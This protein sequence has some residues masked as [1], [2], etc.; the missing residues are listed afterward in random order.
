MVGEHREAMLHP[1]NTLAGVVGGLY[2]AFKGGVNSGSA[3]N[4]SEGHG[5]NH[6]HAARAHFVGDIANSAHR[7]YVI[8]PAI[9]RDRECTDSSEDAISLCC[10]HVER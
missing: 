6:S 9:L 4:W 1:E 8:H 10:V 7:V 5:N 2:G 3:L